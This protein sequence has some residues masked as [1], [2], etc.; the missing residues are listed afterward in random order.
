[1][2]W[3]LLFGPARMVAA[4]MDESA[5]MA[6]QRLRKSLTELKHPSVNRIRAALNDEWVPHICRQIKFNCTKSVWQTAFPGPDS[7]PKQRYMFVAQLGQA[8][9]ASDATQH[10]QQQGVRAMSTAPV[11]SL[12][13]ACL[14]WR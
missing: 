14:A 4:R 11:G 12:N 9:D 5:L 2:A 10:Q 1:M 13:T 6:L 7:I 3:G 8:A